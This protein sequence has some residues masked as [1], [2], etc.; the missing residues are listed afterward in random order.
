MEQCALRSC[1]VSIALLYTKQS[2]RIKHT[3][4]SAAQQAV[5]CSGLASKF[6]RRTLTLVIASC[7]TIASLKYILIIS[8]LLSLLLFTLV[9]VLARLEA[10]RTYVR[11][12][13]QTLRDDP[14]VF[15]AQSTAA[16]HA[17]V[18]AAPTT[19]AAT[20]ATAATTTSTSTI[21]VDPDIEA[22][23]YYCNVT[24]GHWSGVLYATYWRL[25]IVTSVVGGFAARTT[26]VFL[27]DILKIQPSKGRWGRDT[28]EVL[29]AVAGEEQSQRLVFAPTTVLAQ[30]LKE[31]LGIMVKLHVDSS[32]YAAFK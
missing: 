22:P 5:R 13:L 3:L 15:K 19:A 14:T 11:E 21:A 30:D 24:A 8:L 16:F 12:L 1:K 32:Y 18:K 27:K 25:C 23:V 9:Q 26:V 10:S 17:A 29:F 2:A 7:S 6:Q 31:L 4:R 28:L 20:T